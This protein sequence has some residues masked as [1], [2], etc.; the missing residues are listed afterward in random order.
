VH[1]SDQITQ[2]IIMIEIIIEKVKQHFCRNNSSLGS[3]F[4][5]CFCFW[6]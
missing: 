4:C 2:G 6:V 5:F 1:I 3:I